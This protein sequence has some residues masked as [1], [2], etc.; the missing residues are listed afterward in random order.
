[1]AATT[2]RPTTI[3]IDQETR[4]RMKRLVEARNRTPHWMTLEAVLQY[5]D[6]KEK[7]KAFRHDGI[8]AWNEYQ[9]SGS[10]VSG[11]EVI[12]WLD[13]WCEEIEKTAPACHL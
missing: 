9:G 4:E 12:A 1:M 2:T 6:R 8:L 3:K 5:V 11:D 7:R 13:T 10:H